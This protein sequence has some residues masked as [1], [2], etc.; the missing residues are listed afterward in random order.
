MI[1]NCI[2]RHVPS[3]LDLSW[4]TTYNFN[5]NPHII[6]AEPRYPNTCPNELMARY[7]FLKNSTPSA[8]RASS[9]IGTWYECS[10]NTCSQ[11]F[12]PPFFRLRST[13]AKAWSI[14]A[15]IFWWV[16]KV[17]RSQTPVHGV[18]STIYFIQKARP[19]DSCGY[20]G[21]RIRCDHQCGR[22]GCNRSLVLL[23]SPS[24][25]SFEVLEIGIFNRDNE[26]LY[27]L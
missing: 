18:I 5:L 4:V 9:L 12:P 24:R 23:S 20:F 3:D 21:L 2:S 11:L 22:L 7:P 15:L 1:H 26:T 17:R 14:C 13:L 25:R 27:G 19:R 8:S 16:T 10:R 6:L